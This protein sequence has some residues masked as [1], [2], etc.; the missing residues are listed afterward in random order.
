MEQPIVGDVLRVIHR[1][2]SCRDDT[3]PWLLISERKQPLTRQAVN[4]IVRSAGTRVMLGHIH[5]HMLRHSCG[6]ALANKVHNLRLIQD[7]LGHR[8][9]S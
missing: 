2:F 3:L 8:P 9:P 6:F 4:Y 7:Y 5:P 1:W